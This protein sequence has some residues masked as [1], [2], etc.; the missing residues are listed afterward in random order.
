ML[1]HSGWSLGTWWSM[2]WSV[3]TV[4]LTQ[5]T[6]TWEKSL[7]EGLSRWGWP[8]GIDQDDSLDHINGSWKPH[9]L[10]VAPLPRQGIPDCIRMK[11]ASW[12]TNTLALI[13]RCLFLTVDTIVSAASC[14]CCL[15]SPIMT[16]YDL[17]L[18]PTWAL[19]PLSSLFWGLLSQ[20]QETKKR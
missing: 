20:Q 2:W 15:T 12:S 19:S 14:P 4:S 5:S 17:E 8:V 9:L 1:T 7:D 11:K 16:G 13:P 18:W 3:L 10:W 6:I